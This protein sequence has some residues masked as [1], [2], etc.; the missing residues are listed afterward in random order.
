MDY[1][2]IKN[3][4]VAMDGRLL[5]KDV[6]IGSEKIIAVGDY[7]EKPESET[8][9]IDA[10]GKFVMPAAIDTNIFFNELIGQDANARRRFN[11]AQ[12]LCGT[13]SVVAPLPQPHSYSFEAE[14]MQRKCNQEGL[15]T[16]YGYHLCINDW[17]RLDI[18]D[19]KY[20][21][22]HEGISTF[23][24]KWP[25]EKGDLNK[26][27]DLFKMAGLNQTTVLID[28]KRSFDDYQQ[29]DS[30][31][32]KAGM[33]ISEHLIDFKSL[34]DLANEVK[35]N[36]CLLNI[37]F[38]EELELINKSMAD[39]IFAELMFPYHIADSAVLGLDAN[40]IYSGFPLANK[41]RLLSATD[42]WQSLQLDNFMISRPLLKLSS[43]G[44]WDNSQVDNRPDEYILR[45]NL[46]SVLYTL[47]VTN[48]ELLFAKL[49]DVFAAR[50]AK[51]MG[52]YPQKGAMIAGSDADIVVWDPDF[53]R[54]VYCHMS[55]TPS[56]KV[57]VF[58]LKG[59]V[60]FSFVKGRMVYNGESFNEEGVNARYL[61]RSPFS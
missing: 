21:Y 7:I 8:P 5:S 53:K 22:A 26:V 48:G 50:T 33:L 13:S 11:Q 38:K 16:D 9:V 1:V 14:L 40:S 49:V 55:G 31:Y 43:K 4:K 34:L 25:V 27:R 37:Y 36:V 20:C 46:L 19:L 28:L 45:K 61:Y 12:V 52:V 60:E 24:M 10:L 39:N 57:E 32:H 59:R 35:C 51:L 41:L 2:L 42:V 23:Y 29:V 58:P 15:I 44:V 47:G 54:N 56:N 30:V 6:L 18:E 3:G 17:K